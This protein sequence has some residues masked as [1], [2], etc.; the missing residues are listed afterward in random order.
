MKLNIQTIPRDICG[1]MAQAL[2]SV[3][4]LLCTT[5]PSHVSA[6]HCLFVYKQTESRFNRTED[7]V[8]MTSGV[9]VKDM[10]HN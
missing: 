7:Y 10:M 4:V 5:A 8:S 1:M 2:C 9:T 3:F 6:I